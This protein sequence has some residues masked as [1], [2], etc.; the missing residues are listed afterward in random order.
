[1]EIKPS[2]FVLTIEHKL[3]AGKEYLAKVDG[4]MRRVRV[5]SIMKN[6]NIVVRTMRGQREIGV[7]ILS[8][9][10]FMFDRAMYE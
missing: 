6:G 2:T 8:V 3:L 1:M 4:T 10:D 5:A 7:L 9:D